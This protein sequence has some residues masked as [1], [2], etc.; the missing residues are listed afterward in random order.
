MIK[1]FRNI[2]FIN[3]NNCEIKLI[4]IKHLL[5]IKIIKKMKNNSVMPRGNLPLLLRDKSPLLSTN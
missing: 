4:N 3:L 1:I 5:T 2:L